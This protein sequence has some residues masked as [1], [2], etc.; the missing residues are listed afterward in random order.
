MVG[1]N[2]MSIFSKEIVNIIN[3]VDTFLL[4]VSMAALGIETSLEKMK[5][6]GMKPIYAAFVVFVYLFVVGY[7]VTLVFHKVL[8]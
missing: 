6:A 1:V 8:T 2:S 7:I 4:T 3:Q 5:K